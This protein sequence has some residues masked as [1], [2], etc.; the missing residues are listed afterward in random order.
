MTQL[1]YL[2]TL[3]A[4]QLGRLMCGLMDELMDSCAKC[5]MYGRCDK[6]HNGWIDYL[7]SE[8]KDSKEGNK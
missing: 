6:N 3:D 1:E 2:K 7:K 4:D 5:P 8:R